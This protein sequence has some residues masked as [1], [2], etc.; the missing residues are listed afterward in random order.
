MVLKDVVHDR[1]AHLSLGYGKAEHQDR[2]QVSRAE[3]R[4]E[5]ERE[6]EKGF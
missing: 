4:T 1:M 2:E 6:R 3:L 5:R